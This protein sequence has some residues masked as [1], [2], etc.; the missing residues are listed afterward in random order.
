MDD[1]EFDRR[2][3]RAAAEAIGV[4]PDGDLC[5]DCEAIANGDGTLDEKL[6]ELGNGI[7]RRFNGRRSR[8]E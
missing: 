4:D 5:P 3:L 1:A 6:A 8:G 7:A 2:A